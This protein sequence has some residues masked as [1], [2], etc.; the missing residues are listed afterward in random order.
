MW[1][2][3]GTQGKVLTWGSARRAGQEYLS[4]NEVYPG[5]SMTR[6][7]VHRDGFLRATA[8]QTNETSPAR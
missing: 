8:T 6:R 4:G 3:L 7:N 1:V 2:P 5:Q